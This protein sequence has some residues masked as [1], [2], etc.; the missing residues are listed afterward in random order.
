MLYWSSMLFAGFFALY[1]YKKGF[2]ESWALLFN[3]VISIYLA[4][5]LRPAITTLI[6]AADNTAYNRALLVIAIGAASFVILHGLSYALVTGQFAIA[7][8][9]ILDTVG[10]AFFG[11]LTGLLIFSFVIVIINV[12]PLADEKLV[13]SVGFNRP[14]AKRNFTYV[15]RWCDWVNK[16]AAAPDSRHSTAQLLNGLRQTA[17]SK[18]SRKSA[19]ESTESAAPNE[20]NNSQP[21]VSREKGETKE[22]PSAKS[23]N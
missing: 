9:K 10:A 18:P 6:P 17:A 16:I 2:Y 15:S 8:P 12:T 13:K 7:F 23:Q 19:A 20:P 4:V 11:F 3:V 22:Q 21:A 1:A 14:F 5:F